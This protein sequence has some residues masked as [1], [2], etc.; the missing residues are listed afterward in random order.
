MQYADS[1]TPRKPTA[2]NG[3][4][5]QTPNGAS[6]VKGHHKAM[7]SLRGLDNMMAQVLEVIKPTQ[8]CCSP[9]VDDALS[10][11]VDSKTRS[12]KKRKSLED[13]K[14][15]LMETIKFQKELGE[16]WHDKYQEYLAICAK[17]NN[18]INNAME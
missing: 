2:A 17:L 1:R 10:L 15:L 9:L 12:K 7:D 14:N 5:N 3:K 18:E 8:K 11:P 4:G 16:E 13:A 6:A